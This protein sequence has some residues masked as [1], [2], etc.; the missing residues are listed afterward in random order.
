MLCL[1]VISYVAGIGPDLTTE[2]LL[3]SIAAALHLNN[4]PVVGQSQS[5]AKFSKN[6]TVHVN[7]NQ[8][9]VQVNTI[10]FCHAVVGVGAHCTPNHLP[11]VFQNGSFD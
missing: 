4:Q 10:S 6:P 5:V 8:P 9:L 1:A 11:I 2:N 7:T 3:Q